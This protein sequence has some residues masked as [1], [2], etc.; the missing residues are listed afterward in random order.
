MEAYR[1]F[2]RVYDMFMDNVPYEEW[3]GYLT[4][5][6]EEYGVKNGILLDL[7]CGTGSLTELLAEKGYDMIG[8]DNSEDMLEIA[9]E[10]REKSGRDI[11]Y[12]MQDMREFEL[13]G[14]VR[15]AVSICDSIN[16]ILDY[17][18]LV[19]VFSLVNNYLDP[20]GIF[21]FDC[22]TEY[23]YRE[24]LADNVIAENRDEGSFIWE[25][26]YYDDER[27]NE[28][29]LT[30]FIKEGEQYTKYVETHYQRCYRIDEI[31]KALKEAGMRLE[32]VYDAFTRE[33][34]K[35]DSERIYFIAREQ[36]KK[37]KKI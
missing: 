11:L 5:L 34:P 26:Y 33:T 36:G 8:V 10:K 27:M 16:Y 18:E 12:L 21:I 37:E 2:A 29:D 3:C 22:N 9:V 30:L 1:S 20:G 4:G 31:E 15:A 19:Q 24:L 32:A 14:T 35:P 23:K 6:L 13:Y 7:G 25:N 17:D 28:Y